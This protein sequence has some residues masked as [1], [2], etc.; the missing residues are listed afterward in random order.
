[1]QLPALK[2]KYLLYK[3]YAKATIN[4]LFSKEGIDGA[5][6]YMAH[7]FY[8]SV[9]LSKPDGTWQIDPLNIEAQFAPVFGTLINDYDS[10]G[11][12]DI[13][14][15]G[16]D[17]SVPGDGKALVELFN[18]KNKRMIL[19]SQNNDRLIALSQSVDVQNRIIPSMH[20]DAYALI[21][22][23][24]GKK[25]KRELYY[26]SGYLSGSARYFSIPLNAASIEVV[27]FTGRSR[28]LSF[29]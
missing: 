7:T 17:F 16:N 10:D 2:K 5:T 1:M 29:D 25:I 13:L 26:G 23:K 19:A 27:D 20:H 15:I 18:E 8:T 9:M 12:D 24:D 28:K 4:D 14:M 21:S 11:L 3:D 6:K 22:L